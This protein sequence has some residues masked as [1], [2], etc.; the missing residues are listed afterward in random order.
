MGICNKLGTGCGNTYDAPI[1]NNNPCCPDSSGCCPGICPDFSIK[2]KDTIPAFKAA[3]EDCDGPLNLQ[4]SRIILEANMW[5]KAK[6]KHKLEPETTE[7]ALA[8]NI[9][10]YQVMIGDIII[11]D[12][13]RSPEH[14]LVTGFDEDNK[15]IQV[16]RGYNGTN[17]STWAK[18]S[19]MKIFKFI[20]APA[21][22]GTIREDIT[23]PDGTT[24]NVVTDTFLVYEWITADTCLP[25]CYWLEFKAFEMEAPIVIPNEI[26]YIST[27][28]Y[29]CN[30]LGVKWVRKFPVNGE[31]FLIQ[32][33][34]SPTEV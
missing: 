8:D 17:I 22:I 29:H 24:E 2:R 12:R 26:S 23:Q 25:A 33:I 6:L 13:I 7:F 1:A 15:L 27:D 16:E 30:P 28:V 3:V 9:G 18:G 32:I 14:M 10:F 21:T 19:S 34:D 5:A 4:G 11:M 31:G 20:N